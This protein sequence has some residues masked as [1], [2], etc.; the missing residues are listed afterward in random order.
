MQMRTC[1]DACAI[2][3]SAGASTQSMLDEAECRQFFRDYDQHSLYVQDV[4]AICPNQ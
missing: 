2:I 1:L 4:W 3:T